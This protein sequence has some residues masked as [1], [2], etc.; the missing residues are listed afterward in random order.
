MVPSAFVEL[1]ALPLTANQ[2]VDR[3]GAAGAG[4][5]PRRAARPAHGGRRDPVRAVCRGAGARAGR[6]RRQFLCTRRRQHRVDPAGEP[7]PAGRPDHHP[8]RRVPAADRCGPGGSHHDDRRASGHGVRPSG[9]RAAGNADHRAS[10]RAGSWRRSR[11]CIRRCCCGRRQ[12]CARTIL[13]RRCSTC[14]TITMRCG[15]A[16][17][18]SARRGTWRFRRCGSVRAS[19]GLRR[20]D[21]A[22]VADTALRELIR[23]EVRAP[24][25]P[26]LLRRW[27]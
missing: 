12:G 6:D 3:R 22:G 18:L 15:C 5:S 11:A 10:A 26:G 21:V 25:L 14:S 7:G 4:A 19:D 8:A 23:A 9:R 17:R 1:E 20:V 24:P 2:K 27:A 13:R 16:R